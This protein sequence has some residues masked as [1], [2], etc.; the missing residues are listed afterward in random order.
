MNEKEI[1]DKFIEARALLEGH[2][3][4]SSGLH[5]AKYIQCARVMMFPEI[6]SQLCGQLAKLISQKF[7]T[8]DMIVS[9]AMGGVIVGYEVA[10]QLKCPAVFFERVEGNFKLRRGF[11]IEN[12]QRCLMVEDIVTTGLSSRECIAAINQNGGKVVG[13]ACLIDR[14]SGFA[15][16]GV[17]LVSLAQ[18]QIDTYSELEIPDWLNALPIT[19]PGSRNLK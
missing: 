8:I 15:D 10:R 3:V 2:F 13:A 17:D 18:M 7:E 16:V 5:S 9:P 11:E 4:L 6:A 12:G 1:F 19:K 14:S